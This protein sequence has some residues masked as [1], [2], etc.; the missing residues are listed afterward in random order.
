MLR[1]V[2]DRLLT[3][4]AGVLT[5]VTRALAPVL[6]PVG[7]VLAPLT[8]GLARVLTPP[9]PDPDPAD[10]AVPDPADPAVPDPAAGTPP[11]TSAPT[12]PATPGAEAAPDPAVDNHAAVGPLAETEP[13]RAL[14]RAAPTGVREAATLP[15]PDAPAPTRPAPASAHHTGTLATGA[16]GP[17]QGH[18]AD[19]ATTGWTPPDQDVRRRLPDA[20]ATLPSRSPRPGTRPA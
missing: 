19:A 13:S 16:A 8:Q 12:P 20:G 18:P 11:D 3:P 10:P 17:A 14:I 9:R 5:P 1:P 7:R 4:V 15:R 2:H 6:A